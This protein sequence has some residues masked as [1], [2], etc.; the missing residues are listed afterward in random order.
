M[1]YGPVTLRLSLEA[2]YRVAV[3]RSSPGRK[4]A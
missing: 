1:P 4:S 3:P 2:K